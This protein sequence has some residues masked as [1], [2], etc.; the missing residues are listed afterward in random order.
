MKRKYFAWLLAV[1][2]IF[3]IFAQAQS[4]AD[5]QS[6]ISRLIAQMQQ[7]V[8]SWPG[9]VLGVSTSA[10]LLPLKLIDAK[11]DYNGYA[12]VFPAKTGTLS[13]S[14]ISTS[15]AFS[16][17][18][19]NPQTIAILVIDFAGNNVPLNNFSTK[20]LPGLQKQINDFLN[21]YK[22]TSYG[23]YNPKVTIFYDSVK[24]TP[25]T[26]PNLPLTQYGYYQTNIADDALKLCNQNP[27]LPCYGIT[28]QGTS[29]T[30]YT[31]VPNS[32]PAKRFD[33]LITIPITVPTFNGIGVPDL[34]AGSYYPLYDYG[35]TDPW[36]HSQS[37]AYL[38][39]A[40]SAD[41]TPIGSAGI[42]WPTAGRLAHEFGHVLGLTHP[43]FGA[44][45]IMLFGYDNTVNG[46]SKPSPFSAWSK[47]VKGWI[48]P[49]VI[50]N[51]GTYTIGL[52]ELD[53]TQ[54][55][56]IP[57]PHGRPGEFYLLEYRKG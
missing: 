23:T 26:L 24:D 30:G 13:L 29:N 1:V 46:V 7:L 52:G 21:Y 25:F 36:G 37:Y 16:S 32:D 12:K 5:L 40:T 50:T 38:Q 20:Y 10:T 3:P 47:L 34:V 48:A 49:Q 44:W 27:S 53:K 8:Q 56:K 42:T 17:L 19:N 31:N 2:L 35:F 28:G 41:G 11:T 22:V 9:K 18:Q 15:T 43:P 54:F 14:S 51:P 39:I 33:S 4:L 6:Q 57:L 45:D 55:I